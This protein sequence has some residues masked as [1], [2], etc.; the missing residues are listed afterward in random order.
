MNGSHKFKQWTYARTPNCFYYFKDHD[1]NIIINENQ[2]SKL[3]V[4]PTAKLSIIGKIV[5]VGSSAY[6]PFSYG[7]F[8][9]VSVKKDDEGKKSVTCDFS[10]NLQPSLGSLISSCIGF[11]NGGLVFIKYTLLLR[12]LVKIA[13]EDDNDILLLFRVF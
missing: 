13:K 10:T 3:P 12:H 4:G 1:E 2:I 6:T 11:D 7:K 9:D 8:A 5:F